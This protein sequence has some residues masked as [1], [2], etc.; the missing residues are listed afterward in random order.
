MRRRVVLGFIAVAA[1]AGLTAGVVASD[2]DGDPAAPPT[3]P[4]APTT[5]VPTG[6]PSPGA[7]DADDPYYPGLGN[8]GYDV[9]HYALDLSWSP[10]TERLDGV[11]TIEATATQWLSRFS[12][13][14]VG[15]RVESVTI[16]GE[17]VVAD[18]QGERELVLEPPLPIPFGRSFTVEVTYGGVPEVLAP[19][20][21]LL[22]PGWV[23]DGRETH[24]IGEPDGASAFFPANDHPTDKATY[25]LR[26]TVPDDL[27]VAAN[28]LHVDTV[29]GDGVATWVYEATDPMATYLVQVVIGNLEFPDPSVGPDGLTIRHAVD[30]DLPDDALDALDRTAEMLEVYE[31]LFGPYPFA[32]YGV[33]V[34]DEPLGLALE[35]QTLTLV[36]SDAIADESIL[37][38][39]LA[40]QWFGNDVSPGSWRDIWLNEGFATYAEWLW[41]ERS[42]GPSADVLADRVAED[43]PDLDLAPADPGPEDLFADSVYQRGALT[44][45][46]LRHELG[47]D[48]FFE[49]LRAWIERYGGRTAT[50]AD[51]EGLASQVAGEDMTPLFDAWLR[52]GDEPDLGDWLD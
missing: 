29:E 36:G 15:M 31:E 43:G 9:T 38:H 50:S 11:A 33:A 16:D 34:V 40:H 42:G 24:V 18:R 27:A 14:L 17:E 52:A 10:S 12:L 20:A 39:E 51:F 47:D 7:M 41:S 35:S 2:G 23:S 8:G 28:G 45:H 46:V 37:A 22:E 32:A 1:I 30:A 44:L 26:V 49:L 48:A 19:R 25:E 13:D 5:T 6:R 4:T 21:Q 3:V